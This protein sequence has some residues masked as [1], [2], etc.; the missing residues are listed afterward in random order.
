MAGNDKAWERGIY[1]LNSNKVFVCDIS[2][3]MAAGYPFYGRWLVPSAKITMS[4]STKSE[5]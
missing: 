1:C 5:N 3:N 4:P 2:R